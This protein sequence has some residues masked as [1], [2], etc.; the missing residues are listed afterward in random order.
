MGKKRKTLG[1]LAAN[2]SLFHPSPPF[3]SKA[4]PPLGLPHHYFIETWAGASF[5]KT[6]FFMLFWET[7][8]L[9]GAMT[10]RTFETWCC[11]CI[12]KTLRV[13]VKKMR[14]CLSAE[15]WPVK[16]LRCQFS[17]VAPCVELEECTVHSRTWLGTLWLKSRWCSVC[18]VYSLF[19]MEKPLVVQL[20]AMD[21]AKCVC[22]VYFK[23]GR[24]SG[25]HV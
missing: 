20:P 11:C 10:L 18:T 2:A 4:L 12:L 16:H 7:L 25:A 24:C 15:G 14:L 23:D 21:L 1:A 3:L 5:M 8:H 13:A 22:T 9:T 17:S 6:L 19:S